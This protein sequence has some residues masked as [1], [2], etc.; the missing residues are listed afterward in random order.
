MGGSLGSAWRSSCEISKPV[1]CDDVPSYRILRNDSGDVRA[2]KMGFSWPAMILNLVWFVAN[3][4]WVG[5]FLVF[6]LIAGGLVVL[7]STIQTSPI[8]AFGLFVFAELAILGF[9]GLRGNEWLASHLESRGFSPRQEPS[10]PV[11][12]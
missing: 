12:A 1:G 10:S 2:V 9:L 8:A 4:L 3:G 7:S 6:V 5:A 11:G